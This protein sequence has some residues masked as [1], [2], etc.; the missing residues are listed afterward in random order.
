MSQLNLFNEEDKNSKEWVDMPEF[1]QQRA[2][3]YQSITIHFETLKDRKE[4]EKLIQQNMTDRTKSTW[5]PK[6]RKEKP[7]NYKYVDNDQ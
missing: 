1:N 3:P 5:F 4:L 6:G 2:E 7:S